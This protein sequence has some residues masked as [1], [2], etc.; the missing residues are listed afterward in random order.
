MTIFG[1]VDCDVCL[2]RVTRGFLGQSLTT[3]WPTP[4]SIC[5]HAFPRSGTKL[6]SV[7]SPRMCWIAAYLFFSQD[8]FDRF[9]LFF[10][11]VLIYVVIFGSPAGCL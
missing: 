2:Q 7:S 8:Y 3:K 10:C 6:A 11:K 5:L 4:I 9:L 1:L